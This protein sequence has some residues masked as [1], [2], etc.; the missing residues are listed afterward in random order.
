VHHL[1]KGYIGKSFT[2]GLLGILGTLV[3]CGGGGITSTI[4]TT[5]ASPSNFLFASTYQ[6]RDASADNGWSLASTLEGGSVFFEFPPHVGNLGDYGGNDGVGF[7]RTD[8]DWAT[9]L[10]SS[11][12][13]I[14]LRQAI[15]LP[16]YNSA[17]TTANDY[18]G[19]KVN[20]PDNSSINV[21]A[22]NYVVIQTG[23]SQPS[24]KWWPTTD[25]LQSHET[26]TVVLSNASGS[27][28]CAQDIDLTGTRT[29][30]TSLF[31]SALRTYKVALTEGVG[32]NNFACTGGTLETLKSS[33][34]SVS[35][36]VVGGKAKTTAADIFTLM[37][38]G[39]IGFSK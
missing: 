25:P 39:F 2:L 31:R 13:E 6:P 10:W 21:S 28:S 1:T 33:V 23:N 3:A 36:K 30:S 7:D 17:V 11:Q 20:A 26:F 18:F 19:I 16:A 5:I 22:S 34:A 8:A 4:A 38:V 14:N 15:T 12:S 29:P 32:A 27:I 37:A 9:P 24:T 35:V